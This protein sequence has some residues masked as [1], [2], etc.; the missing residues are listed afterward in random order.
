MGTSKVVF[1]LLCIFIV[2]TEHVLDVDHQIQK[3][4]KDKEKQVTKFSLF[5]M[6]HANNK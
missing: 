3:N 4:M 6:I 2:R 5:S 1:L